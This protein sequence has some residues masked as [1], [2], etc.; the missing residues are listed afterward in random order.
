M[1]NRELTWFPISTAKLTKQE[2][3]SNIR[4]HF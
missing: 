4:P 2:R 3:F 1:G